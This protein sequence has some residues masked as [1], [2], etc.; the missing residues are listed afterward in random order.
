[1]L[2]LLL[3]Y[4]PRWREL[5][6]TSHTSCLRVQRQAVSLSW[7]ALDTMRTVAASTW[8]PLFYLLGPHELPR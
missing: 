3:V 5:A 8:Y 6:P 7:K 1:M 2:L 4:Q